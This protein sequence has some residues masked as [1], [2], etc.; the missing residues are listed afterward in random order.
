MIV[1]HHNEVK[2]FVGGGCLGRG[3][4]VEGGGGVKNLVND[5]CPTK[6]LFGFCFKLMSNV[7]R[8]ECIHKVA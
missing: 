2:V 5:V 6:P 3:C 8:V 4:V 7:V 1:R